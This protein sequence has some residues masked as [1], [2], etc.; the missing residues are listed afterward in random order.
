MLVPFTYNILKR[1]PALMVMIHRD[2]DSGIGAH[3][4]P[5]LPPFLCRSEGAA[6]P[7]DEKEPDPTKTRALESSLWELW[8]HERHY[9]APV[10]T[11]T[12][13][14]SAPFTKPEYAM[15]DFLDHTYSTVN[16]T[17]IVL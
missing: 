14:F 10:S 8:A 12:K 6:D 1:H 15:E 5:S 9:H 4:Y 3:S 16:T 13:V 11:L 17:R 2:G 7:F